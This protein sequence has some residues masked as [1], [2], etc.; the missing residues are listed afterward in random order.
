MVQGNRCRG[1]PWSSSRSRR[2]QEARRSTAQA[3]QVR[4]S[5]GAGSAGRVL[6]VPGPSSSSEDLGESWTLGHRS[7]GRSPGA[8]GG[9]RRSEGRVT[10]TSL[11]WAVSEEPFR[12]PC[13]E[14][15]G[16]GP[17]CRAPPHEEHGAPALKGLNVLCL[18]V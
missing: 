5:A 6:Q 4:G 14:L 10:T 17:V 16:W 2:R 3:A 11:R 15:G 13:G 7:L 18:L 1:R 9:R 12:C 8:E